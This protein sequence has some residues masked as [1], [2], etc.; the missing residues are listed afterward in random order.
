MIKCGLSHLLCLT[1]SKTVIS[2]RILRTSISCGA[3]KAKPCL[4]NSNTQTEPHAVCS[5]FS[6]CSHPST[7]SN[8]LFEIK[9]L[10]AKYYNFLLKVSCS[11]YWRASRSPWAYQPCASHSTPRRRFTQRSTFCFCNFGALKLLSRKVKAFACQLSD[12][13]TEKYR[14]SGTKAPPLITSALMQV[15]C[16]LWKPVWA[17]NN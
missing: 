2:F 12:H 14:R 4:Q 9:L 10:T 6:N 11:K 13:H 3:A 7:P 5:E 1:C 16:A 17:N 8:S 15:L